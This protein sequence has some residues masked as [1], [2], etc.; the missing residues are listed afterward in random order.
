M[1][2]RSWSRTV[3]VEGGRV[4]L[5]LQEGWEP[6]SIRFTPELAASLLDHVEA[7]L[8]SGRVGAQS[9][10]TVTIAGGKLLAA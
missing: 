9:G 5:I 6:L 7:E 8:R 2:A 4:T 1:N 3:E 10:D